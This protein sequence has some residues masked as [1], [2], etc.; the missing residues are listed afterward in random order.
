MFFFF[1]AEDGIRDIG[2]TGVQT[3]AL[4]IFPLWKGGIV[5]D[6]YAPFRAPLTQTPNPCSV[7]LKWVPLSIG[8]KMLEALGRGA[9]HRRSDGLAVL[10]PQVGKQSGDV[11]L[12][13]PAA[14]ASTKQR[15]E[16]LEK[17]GKLGQRLR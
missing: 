12:K 3:C 9:G 8:Q 5:E 13:T 15:S 7:Q 14:L 2:V 11:T 10:A 17:L 4:P 6:Q 1:Q 16:R